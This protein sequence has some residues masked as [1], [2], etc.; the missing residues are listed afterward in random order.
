MF[1]LG[2][3]A[4]QDEIEKLKKSA[5]KGQHSVVSIFLSL[6]ITIWVKFVV[7]SHPCSE[8]FFSGSVF[9]SLQKPLCQIPTLL[10]GH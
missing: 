4:L 2:M 10:E 1:F 5:V 6:S 8:G 9:L 3:S 7:C